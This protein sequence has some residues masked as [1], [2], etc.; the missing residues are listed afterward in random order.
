MDALRLSRRRNIYK[1]DHMPHGRQYY[2]LHAALASDVEVA[3]TRPST[4]T[5]VVYSHAKRAWCCGSVMMQQAAVYVNYTTV[6]EGP[7]WLSTISVGSSTSATLP[8]PWNSPFNDTLAL[9]PTDETLQLRLLIDA[10]MMEVIWQGT[11]VC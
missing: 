5:T 1:R 3:F 9:L 8:P 11:Y 7:A 6:S 2:I 10:T 4:N